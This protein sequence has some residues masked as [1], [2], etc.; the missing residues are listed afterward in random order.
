MSPQD[1]IVARLARVA[2]DRLTLTG[3]VHPHHD[4]NLVVIPANEDGSELGV[5][6][7]GDVTGQTPGEDWEG[8]RTCEGGFGGAGCPVIPPSSKTRRR[9]ARTS[10]TMAATSF[11]RSS[12]DASGQAF[13]HSGSPPA[14]AARAAGPVDQAR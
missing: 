2:G 1:R 13:G 7:V 6:D 14:Q 11:A 10:S 4:V 3:A 9:S 12:K 8:R 5:E